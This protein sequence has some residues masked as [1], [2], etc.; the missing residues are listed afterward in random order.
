VCSNP[1]LAEQTLAAGEQLPVGV[2]AVKFIPSGGFYVEVKV[3]RDSAGGDGWIWSS[4]GSGGV[5]G[6]GSCTGCHGEA[7]PGPGIL[8]DYVYFRV[9][10]P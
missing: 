2:A 3:D 8:G 4:P 5:R 1:L 9:P 7:E 10:A 6:S